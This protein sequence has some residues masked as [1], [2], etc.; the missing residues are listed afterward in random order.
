MQLLPDLRQ[1]SL[2]VMLVL[3][4]S[5]RS[6]LGILF[7]ILVLVTGLAT[8]AVVLKPLDLIMEEAN[9]RGVAVDQRAAMHEMVVYSTPVV[10]WLLDGS[11]SADDAHNARAD[12]TTPPPGSA[13]QPDSATQHQ[14]QRW[15]NYL[16]TEK[17]A[18]LS[19]VYLLLCLCLP[20]LI[21]VGACD[22]VSSDI[23]ARRLRFLLTRANRSTIYLGRAIGMI[24][25]V[26]LT[27]A[28][29]VGII[30][31]YLSTNLS[32][33]P[34]TVIWGWSLRCWLMLV[35]AAIPSVAVCS[36][37]SA[38]FAS[39]F[40]SLALCNIAFT[41]VPLV[42]LIITATTGAAWVKCLYWLLPLPFEMQLFHHDI[43]HV[44]LATLGCLVY[45][46]VY[47]GL[48]LWIFK[49]RDL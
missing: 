31:I 15:S 22:Q 23:Q 36:L 11:G 6:G 39:A 18:P 38:G 41:A 42:P 13:T 8:T 26:A 34:G 5:L 33:Y 49:R 2:V 10:T 12:G 19:A 25:F 46:L 4:N 17:P 20:F 47:L 14:A 29:V 27:L 35:I 9:S 21:A 45:G 24:T 1:L 7:L 32:L 37:I 48:G 44:V 30:A 40:G 3:K 43:W 28:L 16:L